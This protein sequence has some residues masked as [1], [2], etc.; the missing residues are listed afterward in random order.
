MYSPR[1]EYA[2]DYAAIVG[3]IKDKT[4]GMLLYLFIIHYW[5][6]PGRQNMPFTPFVLIFLPVY[7]HCEFSI[8]M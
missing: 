5:K 1:I 2:Y 7:G 8:H 6:N 3:K 4:K